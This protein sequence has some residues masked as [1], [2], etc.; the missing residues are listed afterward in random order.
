MSLN[1]I[2]HFRTED[3]RQE[4]DVFLLCLSHDLNF[5]TLTM[6]V[7]ESKL[8]ALRTDIVNTS[9]EADHI[10]ESRAI[11][12]DVLSIRVLT[13]ILADVLGDGLGDIK[14]VWVGVGIKGLAQLLDL[15]RA[16][17]KILLGYTV[18]RSK[19]TSDHG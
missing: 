12:Y 6:K 8:L 5:L 13:T 4:K 15:P 17:L 9:R 3:R 1:I 2:S 19:H 14:F 16:K 18:L 11:G 7:I 10:R